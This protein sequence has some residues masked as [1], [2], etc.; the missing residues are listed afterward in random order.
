M[1]LE[2]EEYQAESLA[3]EMGGRN[4]G[5][6]GVGDGVGEGDDFV[7]GGWTQGVCAYYKSTAAASAAGPQG[8][9]EKENRY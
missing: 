6:D 2:W 9:M 5:V 1:R 4:E 3:A 8:I 7:G